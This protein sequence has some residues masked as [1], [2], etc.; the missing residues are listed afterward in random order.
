M[1]KWGAGE[2]IVIKLRE[3]TWNQ[4]NSTSPYSQK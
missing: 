4:K 2:N 1:N 3:N